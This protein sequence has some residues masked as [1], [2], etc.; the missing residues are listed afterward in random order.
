MD[1]LTAALRAINLEPP[2]TT[3]A[4]WVPCVQARLAGRRPLG[5]SVSIL[6]N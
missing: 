1:S 4:A 2:A 3:L 5:Q 6:Q